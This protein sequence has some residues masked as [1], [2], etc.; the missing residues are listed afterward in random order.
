MGLPTPCWRPVVGVALIAVFLLACAGCKALCWRRGGGQG[1]LQGAC[2]QCV[3]CP[4]EARPFKAIF[5]APCAAA[6]KLEEIEDLKDLLRQYPD[7]W[8]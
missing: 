8:Q 4:L 7:G 1:S 5:A 6:R 2:A 3:L